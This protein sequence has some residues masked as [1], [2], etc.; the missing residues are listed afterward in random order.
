MVI[1]IVAGFPT[2][3]E[4]RLETCEATRV[5][6]FSSSTSDGRTRGEG[7]VLIRFHL[8][9]Q[10]MANVVIVH[11]HD[12][13]RHVGPYG[14][15]VDTPAL[16]ELADEGVTFRN[17]YCAAPTCSPSRTALA[18]GQSPH[19]AGMLGLAHRGFSLTDY[20]RHLAGVLSRNGYESVL[21]GTQHEVAVDGMDRHEAARS[22]LGYDRTLD[23]DSDAVGDLPFEHGGTEEDLATAAGAAAFVR[24]PD[25]DDPFFL[26]VGLSNTHQPMPLDQDAVDPDRVRPPAPLP[27]VPPVREE[28]AAFHA[29]VRYVDECV[30]TVVD[31]LRAAGRLDDTLLLFT[32]DHGAP[33][34]YMKGTLFDAGVGVSLIARFPDGPRGVA[35][36]ALVSNV[37][38][39]PTIYEYLGIEQP[40]WIEGTSL[41]PLVRGE[42]SSVRDEVYGEV[43]YHAA[44]EPKRCVRT[45]RYTYIRRFDEEYTR[46]VGPNTDDG[47]SKQF[48]L[49][50]GYLDRS[51]PREALYDRYHDPNERENLIDDPAHA[52]VREDLTGRLANWMSR[53]DDPLLDGPVSKPDGARIDRR[54]G[55]HPDEGNT[56]PPDVR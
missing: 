38:L 20:D 53:T 36:D 44:Y 34:P 35:E 27:D 6:P 54:D 12:T 8:E 29:L 43:T 47:P 51:P 56:E 14:H 30:G 15:D 41:L 49:E 11:T 10:A 40:S 48:L 45:E 18:T 23:G 2:T 7:P 25:A 5:F 52:D 31:A 13:G 24:S 21:A 46:V 3:R 19:A 22:V 28:V 33:F 1:N 4:A 16:S 17:A 26:S 37:D 55:V 9:G 50:H 42:A 39:A 32:T